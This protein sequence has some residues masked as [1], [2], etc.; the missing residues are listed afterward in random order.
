VIYFSLC[1]KIIAL[2]EFS[3]FPWVCPVHHSHTHARTHTHTHTH[4]SCT[5]ALLLPYGATHCLRGQRSP[6]SCSRVLHTYYELMQKG[7][8]CMHLATRLDLSCIFHHIW[9]AFVNLR[10]STVFVSVA[11]PQSW[12]CSLWRRLLQ[13]SGSLSF[14]YRR[15]PSPM[16]VFSWCAE[17]LVKQLEEILKMKAQW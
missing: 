3:C 7:F 17:P 16:H 1:V 12:W 14:N 10:S 4:I 5:A 11:D 2:N 8:R 13:I 6:Q 9:H 15:R